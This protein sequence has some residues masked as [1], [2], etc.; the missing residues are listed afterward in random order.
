MSSTYEY[1]HVA[2]SLTSAAACAVLLDHRKTSPFTS[3]PQETGIVIL[4]ERGDS[5]CTQ[6][7]GGVERL[8]RNGRISAVG[9]EGAIVH[10]LY[11]R[12]QDVN[13]GMLQ[14]VPKDYDGEDGRRY[15]STPEDYMRLYRKL[16]SN[17]LPFEQCAGSL[18]TIEFNSDAMKEFADH[19]VLAVAREE[20]RLSSIN[21]YGTD[22]SLFS[23]RQSGIEQAIDFLFVTTILTTDRNH[24]IDVQYGFGGGIQRLLDRV[25]PFSYRKQ[26]RVSQQ[27]LFGT[28]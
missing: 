3:Y 9:T 24:R 27:P 4:V 8:A 25:Q 15:S 7:I 20:G 6:R 17:P 19:P 2:L 10:E 5:N 26:P 22:R 16:L 28:A 14:L 21:R 18:T 13:G 12:M 1:R 23:F 11:G